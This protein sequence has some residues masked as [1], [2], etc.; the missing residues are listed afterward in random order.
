MMDLRNIFYLRRSDR[1]RNMRIIERL[2]CK[3][4][5]LKRIESNVLQQFGHVEDIWGGEWLKNAMGKYRL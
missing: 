4:G 1:V 3:L 2:G 5:V